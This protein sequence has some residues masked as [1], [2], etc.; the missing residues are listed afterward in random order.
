[1][2]QETV[3]AVKAGEYNESQ[4][5]PSLCCKTTNHTHILEEKM[6]RY[7]TYTLCCVPVYINI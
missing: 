6:A 1:M 2:S 5:Y 3:N 7:F 4:I